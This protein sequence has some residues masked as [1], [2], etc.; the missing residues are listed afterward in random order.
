MRILAADIGGTFT[1]FALFGTDPLRLEHGM[2]LPSAVSDFP[3]LLDALTQARP[4]MAPA[5]ADMFVMA[6]SGPVSSQERA[7][8]SNL[9]Y[10]VDVVAARARHTFG[11]ALLVN[12]FEAQA[13]ACLTPALEEAELLLPARGRTA[14]AASSFVFPSR[15]AGLSQAPCVLVGAGTGLGV[16]L[17]VPFGP[18]GSKEQN[19]TDGVDRSAGVR[20]LPSEGGHVPFA[21]MPG[22]EQAF[23]EFAAGRRNLA[24]ARPDDVVTGPG[25]AL[26]HAFLTGND[27]PPAEITGQPGF[28]D[29]STCAMFA[30][31]YARVCRSIALTCLP[32]AGV[33]L[34]GGMAA[35]CPALVRH[36][37]FR[38]EFLNA[39]GQHADVRAGIPVWLNLNQQSGLW[40]AA[41]AAVQTLEA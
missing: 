29:S 6:V 18:R 32:M 9:T 15:H 19:L 4:D 22:E 2:W 33:V 41:R 35:N 34:T 24:Y 36:P 8:P 40:G 25:L 31:F 12:D 11:P 39:P 21:F 17:L 28:A 14:E 30:R 7:Q 38:V 27:L 5:C 1:R 16:A 10:A 26:L 3:S 13:W 37:A 23:A 20:I